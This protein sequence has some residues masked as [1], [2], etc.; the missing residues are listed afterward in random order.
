MTALARIQVSKVCESHSV[1]FGC[2]HGAATSS[3]E[4]IWF[5]FRIALSASATP[6]GSGGTAPSGPL[7][8]YGVLVPWR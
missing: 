2:A 8:S 1:A 7:A 4:A 3:S 6:W 5:I